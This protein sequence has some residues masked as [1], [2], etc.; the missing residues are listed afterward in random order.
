VL[1]LHP[2][3]EM[4]RKNRIDLIADIVDEVTGLGPIQQLMEDADVSEIMVNGPFQVYVERKGRLELTEVTFRDDE[5]A[6]HVLNRILTPRG[7]RCDI[8][9]PLVDARLDDGSRVHAAIPPVALNGPTLTIRRFSQIPYNL[10]KLVEAGAMPSPVGAF[11][12]A[13]VRMRLNIVISG[14]TGSG[15]TTML[16]ALSGEIPEGERVITIEDSAE[17]SLQVPHVV[18]LEA[19]MA[20]TEGTGSVPV[21]E[22]VRNSLRMRPDRIVVGECRGAEALDMLQAMNTG[23]EGSMTTAHANNARELLARIETMVLMAGSGATLKGIREQVASAV[24]LI[25]QVRR[26]HGGKRRVVQV[27]E[28]LE[29]EGDELQVRDL[30]LWRSEGVDAQGHPLGEL[31]PTGESPSFLERMAV[32]GCPPPPGLFASPEADVG[33]KRLQ[34]VQAMLKDSGVEWPL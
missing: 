31:R 21:R 6:Q 16:N 26:L 14:G 24:D 11:L 12:R 17:L 7:R 33:T 20:N 10:E 22:L 29:M 19:R 25:I 1:A 28:L 15:K 23:H 13:C 27:T 34:S 2:E 3:I 32:E 9:S 4:P 5:H 30:F 18:G 8:K